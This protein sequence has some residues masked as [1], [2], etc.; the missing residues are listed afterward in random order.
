MFI[1]KPPNSPKFTISLRKTQ[2]LRGG[3]C[4]SQEPSR[5]GGRGDTPP[6]IPYPI[7]ALGASILAPS[8][9]VWPLVHMLEDVLGSF[10]IYIALYD[11]TLSF[12]RHN[13]SSNASSLL[14]W[15]HNRIM[16]LQPP[17]TPLTW[18]CIFVPIEIPRLSQNPFNN[19]S[20]LMHCLLQPAFNFSIS[21]SVSPTN[22]WKNNKRE[23]TNMFMAIS[24]V[25]N[26][27]DIHRG[28]W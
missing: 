8:V 28:L 24:G 11:D 4:S 16:C 22:P 3:L 10:V 14:S 20:V 23:F 9:L 1:I 15:Y 27:P 21:Q 7:D 26:S 5:H 18:L 19:N 25:S 12:Y 2:F 17:N 13:Y 6:R